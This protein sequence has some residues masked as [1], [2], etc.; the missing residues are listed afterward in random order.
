MPQSKPA[1]TRAVWCGLLFLACLA[2]GRAQPDPLDNDRDWAI[3][4]GDKKG[5]QYSSLNQ[6]DTANVGRLVVAWEYHH[7]EPDGPSMYSNPI[8]VDGLLYFT[9]PTLDVVALDAAT[10]REVW[11]FVSARHFED[12]KVRRGR[13]RGVVYW[14]D[15][16]AG[17]IFHFA[18]DRIYAMDARTGRHLA[19]FGPNGYIDLRQD[20][21]LDPAKV[22]VEVTTPGIVYRDHLIVG[23]R[24]PEGYDSTPGD[25]RSY[26]ARTGKFE[27]I[28]HTVPHP[29]EEGYETWQ[30]EPGETYG[31]ANPWGGFTV[32]EQ[33]GWVFCA[34]GSPAPDFIYGGVR[35]GTNLFG[36]CVL[37]LDAATGRKIWHYQTVHHDIFDYD[38]PPA[39]MLCTVTT[40]SRRRDVVVQLTKMGLTFVLDRDTGE[41]VFP[42]EERPVPP[43]PI[44]LEQAWPTQPFPVKPAPLVR[45][46][47]T[48]A[49]LTNLS[50]TAHTQALELFRRHDNGPIYSPPTERGMITVPGHQGGVEWA[51][52]AFN[53]GNNLLFV[54]ANEFPTINQLIPFHDGEPEADASPAVRGALLYQR[55]CASCHGAERK[56]VPPTIPGLAQPRLTEEQAV[57]I[58]TRGRGNMPAFPQLASVDLHNLFVFLQTAPDDPSVVG[59]RTGGKLKYSSAAPFF[60]DAEGYPAIAPPWGTLNAI[61]LAT[62]DTAWKVPLGEYPELVKRGIRHTGAKS[63]GGP[64]AT[65]GG[66]VFIAATPDEKIRA[67]D[68]RTGALLWEHALPAAG[69]A[70]P[71]TYLLGGR[72]FVVIACGGGGKNG[73]P[74][75]DAVVAFALPAPAGAAGSPE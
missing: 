3:Y 36:N 13:N 12:G 54:N 41:P 23:S 16:D 2:P 4:R 71:S 11:R 32:D 5:S 48:E 68:Q 14:R 53:P 27:W 15:G 75:G 1:F 45:I 62:G 17:R 40:G 64:V 47:I 28:F 74:Y 25:V 18:H 22:S 20:L 72:Q 43:S 37:A 30:F 19:D 58:I 65:A 46:G 33:R 55:N 49:D 9:T 35:K 73:S 8:M 31:G 26:N 34:T 29:G 70:T 6:I 10:G 56:G 59:V 44:D 21:G 67:F 52:G 61:D 24:V 39:P 63:F 7:G 57:A 66:V 50:P 69:Y 38:N 60:A 42:V 51:G